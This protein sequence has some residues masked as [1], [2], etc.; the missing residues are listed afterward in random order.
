MKIYI[1]NIKYNLILRWI[2]KNIDRSQMSYYGIWDENDCQE[3]SHWRKNICKNCKKNNCKC[4]YGEDY[5]NICTAC[6]YKPPKN[7]KI[8]LIILISKLV[9]KFIAG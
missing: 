5:D 6:N 1:K 7:E 2:K 9:A 8:D 3:C 4:K